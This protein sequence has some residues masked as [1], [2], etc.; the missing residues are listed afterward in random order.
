[1]PI[2]IVLLREAQGGNPE[3]VKESQRRRYKKV[4]Q[5]DEV[6]ALDLKWKTGNGSFVVNF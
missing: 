2:D 3:L 5:V 1:M 4:E 6:I